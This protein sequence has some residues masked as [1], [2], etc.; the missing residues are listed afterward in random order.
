MEKM[1]RSLSAK[2]DTAAA[3]R[4]A[5]S[6]WRALTRYVDNGLLEIG[7]VEMWRGSLGLA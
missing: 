2:S 3:I 5:L 1:L 7:R 4:Y 6:H